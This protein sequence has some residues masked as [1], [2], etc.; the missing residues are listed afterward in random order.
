MLKVII[1]THD[2]PA[3]VGLVELVKMKNHLIFLTQI[4]E[5]PKESK[6]TKIIK[7]PDD[8]EDYK[9][10]HNLLRSSLKTNYQKYLNQ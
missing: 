9:S 2:T 7:T 4:K 5:D 10:N 3:E 8:L 1:K 6:I